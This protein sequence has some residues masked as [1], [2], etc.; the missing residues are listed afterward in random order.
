[1]KESI[2]I[3]LVCGLFCLAMLIKNNYTLSTRLKA[4][5]LISDYL[6]NLIREKKYDINVDYYNLMIIEYDKFLWNPF[7]FTK[8]DA[9]KSEYKQALKDFEET[10]KG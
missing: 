1:M 8:Y 9:I 4:I 10:N 7:A 6:E 5:N 2:I 3:L